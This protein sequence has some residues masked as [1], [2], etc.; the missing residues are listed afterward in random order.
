MNPDR[1]FPGPGRVPPSFVRCG[2]LT[3][4]IVTIR[5]HRSVPVQA[6]RDPYFWT[7]ISNPKT[8]A[9]SSWLRTVTMRPRS[10]AETYPL[11]MYDTSPVFRLIVQIRPVAICLAIVCSLC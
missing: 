8:I 3:A 10:M 2:G 5:F 4:V 9:A 6:I 7:A 1:P 11:S